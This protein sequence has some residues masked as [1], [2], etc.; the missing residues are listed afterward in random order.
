MICY[1]DSSALVKRYLTELGSIPLRQFI[2]EADALGTVSVSR[3]E[4]IAALAK[5]VRLGAITREIAEAARGIFRI[6]WTDL[7]EIDVTDALIDRACDLA[8]GYGLRGYDSVLVLAGG[9]GRSTDP[10]HV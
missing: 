5:A 2:A 3:A 10:G 9:L 8:W 1:L 4:V 6:D 7:G